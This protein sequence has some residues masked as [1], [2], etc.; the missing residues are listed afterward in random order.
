[1]SDLDARFADHLRASG[2]LNGIDAA[3]AGVSGGVDSMTLLH[4][5]RFGPAAAALDGITVH[6]AHI[7]HRM[8]EGSRAEGARVEAACARWGVP[9]HLLRAPEPVASEAAGREL[10]YAFL[11]DVRSGLPP[12]AATLTAHTADDQ[13]ETVLFRAARGSGPAG[14]AGIRAVR[15]PGIVRP[16]LSFRRSEIAAFAAARGVPFRD[17]P[18][19]REVRWTR[20]RLRRQILPALEAAVPGA[21]RAL[22]ALAGTMQLHAAALN[23]LLDAEIARLAAHPPAPAAP[24]PATADERNADHDQPAPESP[25]VPGSPSFALCRDALLAL[26]DPVL[27]LVLRRAVARLGGQCG[28]RATALMIRFVRD[29]PS[30]RR[31]DVGAGLVLERDRAIIRLRPASAPPL[32]P[33][34]PDSVSFKP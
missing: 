28:R 15:A 32:S 18:T 30:G 25:P 19:N 12:R 9:F 21:G 7:D 16:L 27:N 34:R 13:A 22:A 1:M 17:D 2:L 33:P 8:H 6:A 11:E 29:S 3:V 10:R 23:E 14:L 4:L 24:A 26:P 5:L 31:I 20:N